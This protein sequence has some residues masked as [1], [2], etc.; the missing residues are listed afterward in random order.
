[1]RTLL[2]TIFCLILATFPASAQ[3]LAPILEAHYKAAAQEKMQKVETIIT[4]GKN[5]YSMAGFESA[6]QIFQ[7]RPNKLRIEGDYQGA[8]VV[9][10]FDGNTGWKYAPAMGIPEPVE[11]RG[12]ELETLLSQIKFENPL[13]NY[14]DQ[15]ASIK[16]VPQEDKTTDHLELTTAGGDKQHFF[17][18]RESHLIK[19]VK[20]SRAMGG[21]ETEIEVLMEDYKSV[22]GIP[23]AHRVVTK[24]NGQVVNTLH[25][26]HVELNKKIDQALFEKPVIQQ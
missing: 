19:T 25:I 4:N 21:S 3:E 5:E 17:I 20:A 18:D 10:T 1:M 15:G 2:L 26:E 13:W 7:S 22:K 11:I 16:I 24:M 8:K 23:L 9:Q 12:Q 14:R 6:F